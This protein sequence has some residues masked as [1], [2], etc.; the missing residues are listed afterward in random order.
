MDRRHALLCREGRDRLAL[1]QQHRVGGD[2]D[3]IR[4]LEDEGLERRGKI[5]LA[6]RVERERFLSEDRRRRL[7][8]VLLH[9]RTRIVRIHQERHLGSRAS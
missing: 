9:R 7:G 3:R 5:V 6:R 4:A 8:V 1:A 2:K